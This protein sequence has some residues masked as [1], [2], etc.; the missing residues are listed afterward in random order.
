MG[1]ACVILTTRLYYKAL[2]L[3]MGDL[4]WQICHSYNRFDDGHCV[5]TGHHKMSVL[6][7]AGAIVFDN[8]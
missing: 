5:V 2:G 4:I 1:Y 3:I 8:P 6:G 7:M